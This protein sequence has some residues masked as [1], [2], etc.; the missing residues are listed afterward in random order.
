[1][2]QKLR[3]VRSH[4][5]VLLKVGGWKGENTIKGGGIALEGKNQGRWAIV[6]KGGGTD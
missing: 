2:Y 1:M 5:G 3:E 6:G 4:D